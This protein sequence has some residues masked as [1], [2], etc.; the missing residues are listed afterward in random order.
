M[1][2][3]NFY[4]S[5]LTNDIGAA[6]T[7]IV[8]DTAPTA[9]S[10]RMTLEARNSTQKEIIRYT[11]VSGNTL[12]G[13][14]RG[15]GGT[16]AK[17]HL[18]GA[19]IEQNAT[20]EDFQ[21]LY[22]AFDSF[23]A[24]NNDWRTI[25]GNPVLSCTYN[26]NRSYDITFTSTV[27]A[28]LSPGMRGRS[29]RTVAAPTQAASL[30]G[31]NQYFSKSSPTGV[32]FTDDF[33]VGAWVKLS[34]YPASG[35]AIASRQNGTS[36]WL[37]YVEGSGQLKLN[38]YNAGGTNFSQVA[39]YQSIP[40]NKWVHV[41]VQLDMSAFTAT[42]TTSYV[43]IDGVDIPVS[44]SRNGTNPTALVQAGNLEIGSVNGGTLPFPGKIV[45]PFVTSAKLT[46]ANARTLYSQGITPALIITCNIVSAWSLSSSDASPLND[47]NTTNNNHLTANGSATTNNADAPWGQLAD[48]TISSTLNHFIIQKV[49]G[50][51]ITVQVP[52]GNTLPT[53]GGITTIE[54]SGVKAPY[55]MPV[56]EEKWE[57]YWINNV[58]LTTTASIAGA[59]QPVSGSD[60][61][62]PVGVWKQRSR[63]V[64]TGSSSGASTFSLQSQWDSAS[65]TSNKEGQ[66]ISRA[67]ATANFD[68]ATHRH[69]DTI[70]LSTATVYRLYAAMTSG[71]GTQ[72]A[73]TEASYFSCMTLTN[74]YL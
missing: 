4:A 64:L 58:T 69:I 28:L 1:G 53:S 14:T 20:A 51:T 19:L 60:F 61:T 7:S 73:Y 47:L 48:G 32:T 13:V 36:G 43:M 24:E 12:T 34:S 29:T 59:W 66:H 62:F 26:G 65:P 11:N 72:S 55:G 22:D 31:T 40:L 42:T 52:E 33:A 27:A 57:L 67:N 50:A 10:G 6:D 56:D 8:V 44:V 49:N 70:S 9:T 71:S 46:Q 2:Y 37:L 15:E 63:I 25:A 3:Q 45:Q 41:A 38:G 39:S 35:G 54:Y 74:G 30:N 5:K 23:A 18:R 21:D 16:S 68:V 17:S